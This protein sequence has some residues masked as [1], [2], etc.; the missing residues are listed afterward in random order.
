MTVDEFK[1]V[2]DKINL[3]YPSSRMWDMETAGRLAATF[4]PYPFKQAAAVVEAWIDAGESHPISPAKLRAELKNLRPA[5]EREAGPDW[6]KSHDHVWG[7]VE[8]KKPGV[9]A[10]NQELKA[11]MPGA[12]LVICANCQWEVVHAPGKWLT[13]GEIAEKAAP[14]EMAQA[15]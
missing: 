6:C 12:R 15:W 3:F 13:I 10:T 14:D 5:G 2:V 1:Q 4:K 9:E 7:L 11:M 8:E